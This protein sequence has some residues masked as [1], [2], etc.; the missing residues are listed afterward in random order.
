MVDSAVAPSIL[1][2]WSKRTMYIGNYNGFGEITQG[3]ASLIFGIDGDI[4][5]T[6]VKTGTIY[7]AQSFLIPAGESYALASNGSRIANCYLDVYSEDFTRLRNHMGGSFASIYHSYTEENMAVTAVRRMID[8]RLKP[9]EAKNLLNN[10]LC[11]SATDA[12]PCLNV[13]PRVVVLVEL[14]RRDPTVTH[15]GQCLAKRVNVSET[16]MQRLF[17]AATGVTVRRFRLW[18]R[19]FL[20]A[21]LVAGG[22]SITDAAVASGFSDASHFNHVFKEMIGMNPSAIM[23][24]RRKM[25]IYAEYP[26][27]CCVHPSDDATIFD[28]IQRMSGCF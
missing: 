12:P 26:N 10:I 7:N 11:M 15:T 9:T 4:E 17:K 13:D 27:A 28:G 23:K 14:I 3:A 24:M 6:H 25:T 21:S 19:L 8:L 20:T 5:I 2:L 22:R 18:H 1:Y 16:T